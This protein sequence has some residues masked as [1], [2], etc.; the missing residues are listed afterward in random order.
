MPTM[1]GVI[2]TR[3]MN[4]YA[5]HLRALGRSDATVRARCYWPELMLRELDATLWQLDA[6][7]V[8]AWMA[9][10]SWSA[11][12]RRQ[13]LVSVRQLCAWALVDDLTQGAKPPRQPRYTAHPIPAG[14]LA[15]AMA[16]ANGQD[17]WLLRLLATTGLRR[18]EAAALTSDMSDGQWLHVTG[19]GGVQRRV[20][21][22]PDV[23]AWVA[24]RRGPVFVTKGG[25]PVTPV[26]LGQMVRRLTGGYGP[27]TLRHRFATDAYANTHDIR[28]VQ[29]LLGHASIATTQIYVACDD[30]AM[31]AAAA[32][33]W[34]A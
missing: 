12:T 10:H 16:A 20:P 6:A 21:M 33:S 26:H 18:A 14:V 2:N 9:Q 1:T 3:A 31:L 29:S 15:D 27:H 24:T 25:L 22:P 32:S 11:A 23:A 13:V 8:E 5:T 7:R 28:A 19:K 4:D 34:A 17:Y 30:E